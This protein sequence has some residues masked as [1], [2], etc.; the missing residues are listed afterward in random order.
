MNFFAQIRLI[1]KAKLCVNLVQL[2][3]RSVIIGK[4][5][6][7]YIKDILKNN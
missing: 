5:K 1:L 7:W 6:K 4:N 3:N 2:P